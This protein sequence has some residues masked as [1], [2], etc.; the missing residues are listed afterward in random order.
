[1]SSPGIDFLPDPQQEAVLAHADGPLLITGGPGTGKTAILRERFA[2]L[3]ADGADPER[4]VLVTGS[5]RAKDASRAA[6]LARLPSSLPGLQ[7]VTVHGLAHRILKDRFEALGYAEPPQVLSAAEQFAKVQELLADQDPSAWPAYGSLLGLRGFADDVR[8][9]LLRAQEEMREPETI[10]E[11]ADRRG[12]TGWH[13]LARFLGEYQ[14][15]LDE[16]NVVDF[17]A[18]LQRAASVAG[19]GDPLFDHVLV[20]DFQDTSLAAEAILRGLGTPDLV[21]AADPGAHVFSF[22]GMS[23]VPLDRFMETFPGASTVALETA[24]RAAEPPAIAAWVAPHTAEE[25]ASIAR[26]LR[27]RHVEDG[28]DWADMAVVV[29]RQGTHLGGLLRALDDA[30]IPRAVP[31]RGLSLTAEAATRPYVLALRWLVADELRREELAE[32]LLTSDVVGLSPAATRGLLR[33][34]AARLGS[35]AHALDVTEGLDDAEAAQ[36]VAARDALAKASL[37]AG[38]S[39]QDAFRALWEELPCSRRLVD[40]ATA[41]AEARRELDTV[42]TFANAVAD[43]GEGGDTSV[44]AFLEGLDAGEHGPGYSAWERARP[45][46]V[47]VLTAHGAAGLEFDTVL[48][49][50]AVEG[51]F[52]SLTRPEP[53][54]DLAVLDRSITNAERTRARIEDER[55]LFD[56]V[57]GRARSR[58]VLAC[59]DTHPDADELSSRSRFVDE[60]AV[61]WTSVPAGP[62]EEP[63][64]VREAQ[65]TWRRTLADLS[66]PAWQRLAAIEGLQALGVDPANWWF[67]RDWTDTGRPLHE[68]LR[69]SYSRL[70]NLANCELQHVL[71][72]DLGLGRDA[73]Y[74]AWVGK[75]VHALI[76]DCEKG[77]IAKTKEAILAAL[78]ARWDERVFPSRAVSVAYRRLVEDRMF[79]NWWFAYGE[80]QSLAVEQY[81]EFQF[82]GVRINGV[83]DRI[84]AILSGGTRITDFKTG[85]PDNAPKAEESL[86]LGI[87][88]LA[89]QRSEDLAEYRPV[90]AVELAFVKGHWRTGEIVTKAWQVSQRSQEEYQAKVEATLS[91]LIAEKK[92]LNEEEVYRPN[93][94]ADCFWCEFKSLCP[95]YAEGRPLFPVDDVRTGARS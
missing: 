11:A 79:P 84:G 95:L 81:F 66:L 93:P 73:G 92:R 60:R 57:L 80:S 90:R 10:A 74:Q 14:A 2:R 58:V 25:H 88:Y 49:T 71:G 61:P 20:D 45:D 40:A 70:S 68:H 46:A 35:T 28:V 62:F 94:A 82:D 5:G 75:V 15:V 87:Y 19:T 54:F 26:E 8:Q 13:E 89:V 38:M 3:L 33:T 91:Q 52:P 69:V 56:M 17:A 23:R 48:V 24:H 4:V 67:Q 51:N 55:R 29:R 30:R 6:L 63:V 64:S 59:A 36:V 86:Q 47:Q 34:A 21:V 1:V 78:D 39:V 12:L 7:V 27:R 41:T 16:L 42:V 22:Q 83:I 37:F 76:E 72:D 44:A 53:M 65:A 9:F 77:A 32:Q 18:L 85:N 31:E 50:G 43:T